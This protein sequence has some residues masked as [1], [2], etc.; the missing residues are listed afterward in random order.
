MRRWVNS[1]ATVMLVLTLCAV[2]QLSA[3]HATE[4]VGCVEL[5]VDASEHAQADGDEVPADSG[6][7][8]PHHHGPC[9]NHHVSVPATDASFV[10]DMRDSTL[11]RATASAGL[12][13][14]VASRDLRP[15]IA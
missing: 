2:L 9:H 11:E 10:Q 4:I 1:I 7:A 5:S 12:T 14:I 8:T 13:S 15:P 6:K 3:A